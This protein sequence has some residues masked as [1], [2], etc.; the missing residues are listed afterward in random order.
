[1]N[2]PGRLQGKV[3]LITGTGGGMGRAAAILFAREGAKVVGCDLNA[4]ANAETE[5]L[6][7]TAGGEMTALGP[8]DLGDP[9]A[10]R[11]WVN[12]AATRYGGVDVLYNNASAIRMAPI[13]QLSV[14]DWQFTLRN[15]L[16]QVFYVTRAA[17]PHLIANGGGSVINVGSIAAV[18]GVEFV[19]QNAH[20][21]AKAGCMA[22]TLQL[23]AEGGKYNIRA[24]SVI[25]GPVVTPATAPLFTS[26]NPPEAFRRLTLDRIPMGR[27]GQPED[28]AKA[29]LFLASDDAEWISGA[30]I[31]VDGGLSTLG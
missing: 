3:A 14:D 5:E 2:T 15:E 23:V 4:A 27:L 13:D 25:P 31:L 11:A 17:W 1:M 9:D 24:N 19:A 6:A 16:D 29:A 21:A 10:A 26:E 18:R 22:L 12:E 30:S 20:A 7:R 28:V 8:V